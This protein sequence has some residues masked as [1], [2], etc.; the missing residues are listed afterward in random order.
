M[1][2]V[3]KNGELFAKPIPS[4]IAPIKLVNYNKNDVMFD[5]R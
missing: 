4:C 1:I 5:M 2:V 3:S